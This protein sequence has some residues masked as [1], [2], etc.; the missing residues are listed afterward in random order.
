[1][2]EEPYEQL[3]SLELEHPVWERFFLPAPLAVV[4]SR[5]AS[6]EFD[7]APKHMVTPLGWDN[8]FGFVCSPQHS[9]F[10]NIEREEAF[11]VSFPRPDQVVL[12]SLT[13]SPR[14]DDGS[15]IAIQGLPT[16]RARWVDGIF[17]QESLLCL[18]CELERIIDGFGSN[19]LIAGKII[20][21]HVHPDALRRLDRDDQDLIRSSPLLVYL[22]PGRFAKIS[23]S[24]A[25]PFPA[26]FRR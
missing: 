23:R 3:V 7:L 16:I 17:L 24:N 8:Y 25:F 4:G 2:P 21:A 6:G 22:H 26:G 15:K 19:C 13:A 18:E 9:T 5:E 11:T 10:R 20:A 14:C 12:T 1:M